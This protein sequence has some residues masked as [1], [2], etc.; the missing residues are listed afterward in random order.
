VV[1]SLASPTRQD[2]AG[3]RPPASARLVPWLAFTAA[4]LPLIVAAVAI[5][6]HRP[7][8]DWGG[9]RALTELGVREAAHGH[10]LLG[11]GG[12]FGWRHPGPLWLQL[13]VPLYELTGHAPWSLSI[14]AMAIH[15]AMIAIAVAV[16]ARAGGARAAAVLAAAVAVYLCATG[17]LYWTN[18]WAGYAITW[19]LLALMALAAHGSS[20]GKVWPFPAA[21]LVGTLLVQTDVSTAVVVV[22]VI[23]AAVVLRLVHHGRTLSVGAPTARGRVAAGALAALVVAAWVPPL[24]QQATHDPGNVTLLVRF[25]RNGAGGHPLRLAAASVGAAMSVFPLGARWVL[26]PGVQEHL[27]AGAWWAVAL[28]VAAF[29]ATVGVAVVGWRRGR[30]FAADLALLTAAGIA[31]AVFSMSRVDGPINFYL[32]TWVTI[33]PVTGVTA[34][35]LVLLPE[36]QPGRRDLAV[37]AALVVAAVA[38]LVE[39]GLHGTEHDWDRAASRDVAAQT[40]LAVH[41]LGASAHGLV[42]VHVVTSDTWPDGA[43]VALQLQRHGARIEVDPNWV[44]LFGDEFAPTKRTPAAELWFAR[45]H[46]APVVQQV[47]GIVKAGSVNGVDVYARRD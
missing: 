3:R 7:V 16:T 35:V 29:A 36:A 32:L 21:V 2:G 1:T 34:A 39:T 17:M 15:I 30:T 8:I 33:L 9:D 43:G 37:V 22:L 14:G 12:R 18:L 23:V 11:I 28:V 47:P 45:P 19:P 26:R 44:F 38:A 46:E 13:L 4:A 31:A 5:V 20:S 24:I 41:A 6:A 40:A 27:G 25:A 10:R 42:R